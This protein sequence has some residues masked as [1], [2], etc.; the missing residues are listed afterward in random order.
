MIVGSCL[1]HLRCYLLKSFRLL[2]SFA[3]MVV[4]HYFY[5]LPIV[6]ILHFK[7]VGELIKCSFA[8]IGTLMIECAAHFI[9]LEWD[10]PFR[11]SH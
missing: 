1:R 6:F 4:N 10:F 3:A 9:A 11:F 5:L 2:D 7:I 8:E